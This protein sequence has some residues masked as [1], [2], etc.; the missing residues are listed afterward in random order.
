M[1]GIDLYFLFKGQRDYVHGTDMYEKIADFVRES[2]RTP[3][4]GEFRMTI[5]DTVRHQCRLMY[6]DLHASTSKPNN[7]K[8]EFS[9]ISEDFS[10]IGWLVETASPVIERY[11]YEEEKIIEGCSV[12]GKA[13]EVQGGTGYS[14]IEVTVAM[15]KHL[16]LQLFPQTDGKWFFTRIDLRKL[17]DRQ[18]RHIYRIELAGVLQNRMTRSVIV[19]NGKTV[20][21]IY[22]SLVGL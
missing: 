2:S 19:S 13:I 10:I 5:H 20:G 16:H 22:F 3:G 17:L 6:C 21:Y 12:T 8:A 1:H 7:A 15:N 18:C 11:A 4:T 9:F 14:A